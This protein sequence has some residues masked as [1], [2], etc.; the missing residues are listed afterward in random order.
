MNIEI[1][2]KFLVTGD[3]WRRGAVGR[4]IR[5]GYLGIDKERTVRVR[6]TEEGG[7]I[8]VKGRSAGSVRSEFEYAIPC[9]EAEQM[10]ESLCL[11]PLIEKTRFVVRHGGKEWE[12]DV[13][14]GVHEGLMLAE[15]EL[16]DRGEEVALPPW[17]GEEV[18]GDPRFENA[19]LVSRP[20]SKW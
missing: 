5:Q 13:F 12:V 8:T 17:V 18:T 6:A 7:W 9:A 10:L 19:S 14:T 16:R 11:R 3:G 2:R 4:S 1:E 20:R 15:V